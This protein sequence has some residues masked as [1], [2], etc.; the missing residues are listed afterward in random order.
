MFTS[1]ISEATALG[2]WSHGMAVHRRIGSPHR[3]SPNCVRM[4]E[5]DAATR[6]Y[7]VFPLCVS[8][9]LIWI[10]GPER[11]WHFMYS[12]FEPQV[13]L[14]GTGPSW[15]HA[16]PLKAVI[17]FGLLKQ[18]ELN[19][20]LHVQDQC[21]GCWCLRAQLQCWFSFSSV[22]HRPCWKPSLGESPLHA[23]NQSRCWSK[24]AAFPNQD[25]TVESIQAHQ[26]WKAR[27]LPAVVPAE[28]LLC[29]AR[30]GVVF[31]SAP[32]MNVSS[33]CFQD[34]NIMR[35]LQLFENVM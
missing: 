35:S 14:W 30:L 34:D 5:V 29:H 24:S 15:Q 11:G 16:C 22:K 17:S 13:F 2:Q 4:S 3:A 23:S 31:I 33:R 6:N 8:N 12:C 9:S 28:P 21:S 10:Q 26:G 32:F 20:H 27:L 7:L 1:A 25:L 19:T 18:M